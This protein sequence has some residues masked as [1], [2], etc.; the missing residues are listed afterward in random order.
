MAEP[1]HHRVD[2]EAQALQHQYPPP[3]IP[4]VFVLSGPSGTGKDAVLEHLKGLNVRVHRAVTATTRPRRPGEVHGVDYFFLSSQ[5]FT[6]LEQRGA[7][8]ERVEMYGHRY[9]TPIEELRAPLA[10]GE[11]VVLKI[12]VCGAR[13]V[14]ARLPDAVLIFLAP[15]SL[16]ELTARLRLRRTETPEEIEQRVRQ[17]YRELCELPNYDY[18]IVNEPAQVTRAAEQLRCI[19]EAQRRRLGRQRISL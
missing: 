18:L 1:A 3:Q 17:A 19:I 16:D 11:D 14:R 12:D 13:Q 5:A 6:D 15:P 2:L 8:I 9:G 7:F 4:S 10:R